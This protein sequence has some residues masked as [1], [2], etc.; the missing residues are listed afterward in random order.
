MYDR[1]RN[2]LF[3]VAGAVLVASSPAQIQR[4]EPVELPEPKYDV[5]LRRSIMVPM[6]DGLEL[7]TDLYFPEGAGDELP[8]VLL[9][10]PYNKNRLWQREVGAPYLFAGQGYVVAVQDKRGRYE[11]YKGRYSMYLG[12]GTDGYDTVDWLV[13]QPWSNG[14]VG[15]YGCSY[16]GDVQMLQSKHRNPHLMAMV[17]QASGGAYG[18]LDDRYRY[19]SFFNGGPFELAFGFG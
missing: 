9:R 5:S 13:R 14:K 7:S 8:V 17:P 19:I 16:L 4:G 1:C 18:Y 15:T 2:F 3:V 10:T 6:R 12:D 11:S